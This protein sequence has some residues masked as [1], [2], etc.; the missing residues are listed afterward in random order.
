MP[1]FTRIH[2]VESDRRIQPL[3]SELLAAAVHSAD[4]GADLHLVTGPRTR[5]TEAAFRIVTDAGRWV[6]RD[7]ATAFDGGTGESLRWTGTHFE[8]ANAIAMNWLQPLD[9]QIRVGTQ[10][11]LSVSLQYRFRAKTRIG[12]AADSLTTKLTGSGLLGWGACEPVTEPWSEERL[13]SYAQLRIP[14][15]TEV[16]AVGADATTTISIT[17]DDQGLSENASLLLG[18]SE[19][20]NVRSRV[21]AA[22]VDLVDGY[23]V[24]FAIAHRRLGPCDLLTSGRLATAP[25]PICIAFGPRA[26]H[27]IGAEALETA[28][29]QP[30]ARVGRARVPGLVFGLGGSGRSGWDALAA[31]IEG[32]GA[33]RI[34]VA[35]PDLAAMPAREPVHD[36]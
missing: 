35:A 11:I 3:S 28:A 1:G 7:D 22:M 23:P 4:S 34:A 8:G 29:M 19:R 32:L 9:P 27:T 13:T 30:P 17:G 10:V 18:L 26:V 12:A 33:E 36:R 25:E 2:R 5:L 6:I 14:D 15:L 20:G 21:R 31:L 24:S 16:T